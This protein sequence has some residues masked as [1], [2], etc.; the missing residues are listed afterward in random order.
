MIQFSGL[1]DY[2]LQVKGANLN[3]HKI[4]INFAC[5]K[6]DHYSSLREFYMGFKNMAS[7][8]ALG[9]ILSH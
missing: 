7:K 1:V 9:K 3:Y 2:I 8:N 6:I 4:T 5:D